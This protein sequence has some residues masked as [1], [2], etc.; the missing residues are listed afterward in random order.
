MNG[1]TQ[2]VMVVIMLGMMSWT[3][4]D[5]RSLRGYVRSEISD[6][7]DRMSGL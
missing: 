5:L 6:L 4:T 3:T 7:S 1:D 2:N